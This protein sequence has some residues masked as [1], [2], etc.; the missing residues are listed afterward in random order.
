MQVNFG[1]NY[2][3]KVIVNILFN[4]NILLA[5]EKK[6]EIKRDAKNRGN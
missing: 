6:Q 5:W 3:N 4:A 2:F 1:I